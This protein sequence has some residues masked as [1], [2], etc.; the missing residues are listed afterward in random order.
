MTILISCFAENKDCPG[1]VLS[2][3][4]IC[5]TQELYADVRLSLP[6]IK[7]HIPNDRSSSFSVLNEPDLITSFR[8]YCRSQCSPCK[9]VGFSH[10]FLIISES[11]SNIRNQTTPFTVHY[12]KIRI[13]LRE[14]TTN[15]AKMHSW[16]SRSEHLHV[17]Q[18]DCSQNSQL[19]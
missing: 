14:L 4:R 17:T 16:G 18:K 2:G 3:H 7:P 1:T 6:E 10:F 19:Q 8:E 13:H 11:P 9:V 5:E 15:S 12:E